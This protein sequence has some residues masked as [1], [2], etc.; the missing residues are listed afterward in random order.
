MVYIREID[1]SRSDDGISITQ[2]KTNDTEEIWQVRRKSNEVKNCED[3]YLMRYNTNVRD[4]L[5]KVVKCY[6]GSN[7]YKF[8]A[9]REAGN[10]VGDISVYSNKDFIEIGYSVYP[11]YNGRGIAAKAVRKLSDILYSDGYTDIR[12]T[13]MKGNA[14]SI[15]TGLNSGYKEIQVSE[16]TNMQGV[17]YNIEDIVVMQFRGGAGYEKES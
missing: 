17:C 15:N 14:A 3:I 11:I 16:Y 8:F 13:I 12:L 7:K 1:T 2:F 10:I 9:I 5:K 4:T 6:T